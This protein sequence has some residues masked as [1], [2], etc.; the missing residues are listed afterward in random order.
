MF[1]KFQECHLNS[2]SLCDYHQSAYRTGLFRE[3]VLQKAQHD[4]TDNESTAFDITDHG[5]L[6]MCLEYSCGLTGSVFILDSVLSQYLEFDVPQV[7]I[8]CKYC[9]AVDTSVEGK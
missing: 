3:V 9:Y 7:H 5:I 8:L 1:A 2:L 6:Q 4:I